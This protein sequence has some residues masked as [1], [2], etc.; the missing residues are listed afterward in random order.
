MVDPADSESYL[1]A[2]CGKPLDLKTCKIN[3]EGRA[4]HSECAASILTSAGNYLSFADLKLG[5]RFTAWCSGCGHEFIAEPRTGERDDVR[6]LRMRTEFEKHK[7]PNI[8]L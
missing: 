3:A 8:R 1:C 4:V 6:I 5:K 7:C 2:I